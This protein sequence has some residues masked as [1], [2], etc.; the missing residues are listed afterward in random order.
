MKYTQQYIKLSC[1]AVVIKVTCYNYLF[2]KKF[3][4]F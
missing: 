1:D 4:I 2:F 3:I